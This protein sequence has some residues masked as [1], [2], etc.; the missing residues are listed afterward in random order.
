MRPSRRT[1]TQ[2]AL[3][4][5]AIDGSTAPQRPGAIDLTYLANEG[6]LIGGGGKKILVDALLREGIPKYYLRPSPATLSRMETATSPFDGIDLVLATHY[7]RDHFD[8]GSVAAHLRA[9]PKAT[10]VSVH[11]A[12]DLVTAAFPAG[13]RERSRILATTPD[14]NQS[15]SLAVSDIPVKVIRLMHGNFQNTGFLVAVAGKKILHLG[16]S[17]A[18][19]SNFDAFDLEKEQ[20]DLALIPYWYF[21]DA[22]GKRVVRDHI[23][24]RRVVAI[25]IG[26]EGRVA[27]DLAGI[28][29]EF[30]DVIL[31]TE[32]GQRWTF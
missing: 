19:V 17:D 11:Q 18:E 6:F 21:L 1:V 16:D 5:L 10:F 20:I 8:A 28:R 26:I 24:A 12:A 29:K 3:A 2:L 25:H 22:E 13:A 4:V 32:P 27:R 30:P 23:R 15:A 9:N 14:R 31:A 7:H